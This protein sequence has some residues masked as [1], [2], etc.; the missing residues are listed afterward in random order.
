MSC[1]E[2]RS[3]VK[4]EDV[5]REEKSLD[6]RCEEIATVDRLVLSIPIALSQLRKFQ[7]SE[8]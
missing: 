1:H 3:V 7:N 5:P 6:D 8:M 4:D 2:N